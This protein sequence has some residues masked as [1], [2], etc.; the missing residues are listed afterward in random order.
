M[1]IVFFCV[2]CMITVALI[3]C[4]GT[5]TLLPLPL[6]S[7]LS[8]QH[9][10]WQ[11]AEPIKQNFKAKFRFPGLK[12]KSTVYLDDRLVPHIV[13]DNDEDA[14]F[15]QGYLHARF[16]LWQ[17]E[18]Q[19]YAAA[20]RISEI[21]G[22]KAVNFDRG[23]RRL[24]MV[25]AAENMLKEMEAN[26]IT[27]AQVDNYTAGVN[28]YI[29]ALPESRLP[30]EY[31]LL[32]YKP[33]KWNNLKTALFV[34]QM[35]QTLSGFSDD[36]PLTQAKAFFGDAALRVLFPQVNDSLDPVIP[37]GTL[38]PPASVTP[39]APAH[40]DSVYINNMAGA[41]QEIEKPNP[42]NGSNNWAV[43]G[44]RTQSGAPILCNDPHLDL[45]FP[46][47]WYEMQ[48]ITPTMNAYGVSFPGAPG[49]IIGF[50]DSIAFGFTNSERDVMDYYAI[51]FKDETK[52]Q[53]RFDSGWKNSQL[54]IE[55]IKVKDKPVVYDTVAYTVFGPVTYDESFPSSAKPGAALA[56]R[57]K[58]HD[59]SNELLT[60]YYLNRANNY[61]DYKNALQYFTNPAHN[62]VFA[63]KAGDIAIWQQ[64]VF[65][66]LWNRQGLYVMP[67][68]DSSYMW[69]GFIPRDE[70]PHILNPERGFVSSA[71]QRPADS[72][73][74]YFIPGYYDLYRG[75]AINRKLHAMQ[76]ITPDDMMK[77]QNDNYNV[78][79]ETAR[80]LLLKYINDSSLNEN[81]RKYLDLVSGWSLYN[82]VNERG[83]TIFK[84][85]Y[86]NL[87]KQ[88][89]DDEFEKAGVAGLRPSDKT[90]TEA[91]LR[92]TAFTYI[93][94]INT[95]GHET[96]AD[97]I[98]SA[99]K[100]AAK[101]ADSLSAVNQLTWGV[102]K[103]TSIYHLLGAAMMPFARTGL[104]V[105]GGTHIIN[106]MQHNHGPSWRMVVEL[107]NETGAYVVY[108]GGQ[109]GNPGSPYYD[110]FVDKWA[111][112]EYYKAWFMKR[113][114]QEG[115]KLVWK[116]EFG[117]E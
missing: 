72:T 112:G 99:Y 42:A 37:K 29:A 52:T 51:Q 2:S 24:G 53:Y 117:R 90:L 23:R 13:A 56:L 9:G 66:A 54:R 70:N 94:N 110:S 15:L 20:G 101:T 109:S 46:S 6:G 73:Y 35:A 108:P 91:L 100:Q 33:E 32:G 93:D 81:E 107:T 62:V 18:F 116:M 92:D 88:V 50:N 5:P 40:A 79:A 22:D 59:P 44:S 106:A 17:M 77:L 4:L 27:K 65:P 28:A 38:F 80:P 86:A 76:N 26:P 89:W 43:S 41:L 36:L 105:G 83:A 7:F 11:N 67:G 115:D 85:W 34:K 47:I 57:W 58:A 30:V 61:E 68:E 98:T 48:V 114:E 71:N 102:N 60:W 78:F 21:V 16:R 113:G 31:K 25:Y 104:P 74:P 63:S 97:V 82:N 12:G 64:G 111:A 103:N 84:L 75:I 96:I 14:C 49:I 10:I 1:R 95:P 55:A 39:V 87:E 69:Q 8:P 19:T 3:I 45:S